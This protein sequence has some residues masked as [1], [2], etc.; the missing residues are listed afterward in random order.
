LKVFVLQLQRE[1]ILSLT[2]LFPE[3]VLFQEFFIF[4]AQLCIAHMTNTELVNFIETFA[5]KKG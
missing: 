1:A 5:Y 4:I 3:A 2:Q